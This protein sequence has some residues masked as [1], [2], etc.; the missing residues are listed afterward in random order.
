MKVKR[1]WFLISCAANNWLTDN[2]S[3][4]G[5]ALAF[6]CA[7]SLAPLLV[8]LV[9]AAGWVVGPDAAYSYLEH[10]LTDLFGSSTSEILIKA[11]QA[12]QS[13]EG[14]VATVVSIITLLIGATTVF[15][16]LDDALERIWGS[17]S[18]APTGVRGFI[19]SR[20]LSFGFIIAIAFLLLVSLTLST[21]MAALRN[22][23]MDRFTG[24]VVFAGV[25]DFMLTTTLT[26]TLFAFA[27]RYMPTR[28]VA[29][30]LVGGGALVTALLFQL[31]RWGVGL[32]LAQSTQ[33]SAFG[34]AA[35]FVALLLW[36][37]YSAQIF[38]FGAE[39]TACMAGLRNTKPEADDEKPT[40]RLRK[41]PRRAGPA[42]RRAEGK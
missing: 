40:R 5:A 30:R 29:W 1:I 3:T 42:D 2:A 26:A 7:F 38:L 32:Y 25:L 36:L 33:A 4:L 10:Q 35:S 14:I 24:W 37:Y 19:R 28:R 21:A 8:L 6:Y 16:A 18:L 23:I 12:S 41:T 17:E 34:A 20:L 9:T 15:A 39:F 13:E 31:G 22:S 27:Y 11:A